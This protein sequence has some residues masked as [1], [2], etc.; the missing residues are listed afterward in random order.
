M[1]FAIIISEKGGAERREL[2]DKNEVVVGRLQ[3]NDLMLQ[4]SNVSKRHAKLIFHNGRFIVTDME[5]TNGT[6]VNGRR[7]GKPTIVR[8]GDKIYV[9]DFVLRCEAGPGTVLAPESSPS[10]PGPR[11][12]TA[13]ELAQI[14]SISSPALREGISHYPLENDPDEVQPKISIPAPPKLPSGLARPGGTQALPPLASPVAPP[15]PPVAPPPVP[16][17]GPITDQGSSAIHTLAHAVA[18]TLPTAPPRPA[19]RSSAPIRVGSP[20]PYTQRTALLTLLNALAERVDLEP[21]RAGTWPVDGSLAQRMEQHLRELIPKLR[22]MGEISESVDTAALLREALRELIGLGPL[23]VLLEDP[24]IGMLQV[25]HPDTILVQRGT[26][27]LTSEVGFSSEVALQR[28]IARL[29]S[30]AGQPLE[31]GEALVERS[32]AT[33]HLLAILPPLS[34]TGSIL[35]LRRLRP[36]PPLEDPVKTG[37][38]SRVAWTFLQQCLGARLG[39]LVAGQPQTIN[40]FSSLLSLLP[41]DERIALVLPD[42]LL[43]SLPP[44]SVAFRLEPGHSERL[45]RQLGRMGFDR[46]LTT[47]DAADAALLDLLSL[48]T[49]APL[50]F[51]SGSGARQTLMRL[52]AQICAS[53]PGLLPPVTREWIASCF[54]LVVEVTRLRDGRL[55]VVRIAEV[56]GVEGDHVVLHEL[57]GA[58][59]DRG[60]SGDSHL[61]PSNVPLHL[62]EELRLR[63][64]SIDPAIFDRTSSR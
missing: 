59:P 29:C 10:A 51:A 60:G 1:S 4:K 50:V 58:V 36:E 11:E 46:I 24:E 2:F 9:G 14:A 26:G 44:Q 3:G 23:G 15:T 27:P 62:L 5:S 54:D 40:F 55:R 18:G 35:L 13:A 21:L 42:D 48:R 33:G 63:G 64:F 25:H 39:I 28:A 38:V 45:F 52:V 22:Q 19:V 47:C 43:L 16:P 49:A 30:Q 41:T 56:N 57:F 8:E 12:A 34:T 7:I 31:A 53:R 20:P 17:Q 6:Y 61:A 37:A 32:L